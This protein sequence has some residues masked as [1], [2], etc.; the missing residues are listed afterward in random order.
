VSR[1]RV[2][3]GRLAKTAIALMIALGVF[4]LLV[5]VTIAAIIIALGVAMY[6]FE[7]WLV[8]KFGR[9]KADPE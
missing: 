9:A 1:P 4:S 6:L 5:S 2:R 8:R 7:W 3:S